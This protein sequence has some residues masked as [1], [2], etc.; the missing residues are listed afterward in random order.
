MLGFFR[1]CHARRRQ[2]ILDVAA[3]DDAEEGAAALTRLLG[4]ARDDW[5]F[6]GTAAPP[7]ADRLLAIGDTSRS[8]RVRQPRQHPE[9]APG[10]SEPAEKGGSR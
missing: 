5:A 3:R 9:H 2:Y 7:R 1:A 6:C 8:G 10:R 4:A